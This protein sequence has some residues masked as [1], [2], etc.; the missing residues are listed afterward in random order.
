[1]AGWESKHPGGARQTLPRT[2]EGMGQL[3]TPGE[4]GHTHISCPTSGHDWGPLIS[5]RA[6]TIICLYHS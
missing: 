5:A 4:L 1:M 6:R 3:S 2:A